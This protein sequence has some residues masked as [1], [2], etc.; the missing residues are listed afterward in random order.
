MSLIFLSVIRKSVIIITTTIILQLPLKAQFEYF[1]FAEKN[2]F[3]ACLRTAQKTVD[4]ATESAPAQNASISLS[5]SRGLN[6]AT[7][8]DLQ[9]RNDSAKGHLDKKR[10]PSQKSTEDGEVL[11]TSRLQRC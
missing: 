9:R 1:V 7:S 10:T 11:R 4:K 8:K 2:S 5:F 3:W 6:P